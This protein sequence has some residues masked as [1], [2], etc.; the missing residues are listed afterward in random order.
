MKNPLLEKWETKLHNLFDDIDN[1][2]EDKYG[3]LYP[4]A[5][6]RKPRGEGINPENDG[7]FDL[8]VT[9]SAGFTSKLGPGY[10]F[11]VKMATLSR[12]PKELTNKIEDEVVS[13][14]KMRLPETFPDK[15]L[16]VARDGNVF[17]IY[18]NL[19]LN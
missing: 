9:F 3:E 8:S 13:I 19:D 6:S 10:I 7:L 17:K 12:V 18:G 2:L 16:K 1:H 14:L 5:P 4:L 11:R 15:D